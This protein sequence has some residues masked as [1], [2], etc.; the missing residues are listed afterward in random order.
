MPDGPS[1]TKVQLNCYYRGEAATSAEAAAGRERN[2]EMW[3]QVNRQDFPFVIGTQATV[4]ARDRAGVRTRFSP[5][6]KEPVHRFQQ[7]VIDAIDR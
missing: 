2:L 6:W 3:G 1:R 4:A 5:C 7:M